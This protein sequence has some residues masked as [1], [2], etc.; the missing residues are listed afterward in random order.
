MYRIMANRVASREGWD[1]ECEAEAAAIRF[2][3]ANPGSPCVVILEKQQYVIAMSP[4]DKQMYE[5]QRYWD[6]I[7]EK[8]RYH[9]EAPMRV[10][11]PLNDGVDHVFV[12]LRT[13]FRMWGF[14][15]ERDRDNFV[16]NHGGEAK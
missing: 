16:K 10:R 2:A 7:S 11:A 13:G 8:Y 15:T 1:L 5:R 9:A 14:L 3:T 4:L 12:N 6:R